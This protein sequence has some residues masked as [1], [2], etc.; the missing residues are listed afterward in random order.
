MK[1]ISFSLYGPD[2]KYTVGAIRNSELAPIVFPGWKMIVY[3]GHDVNRATRATLESKGA[4]V[5]DAIPGIPG[6]LWRFMVNDDPQIERYLIRDTDSRLLPREKRA[7]DAWVASGK[8]FHVI[9]DHPYHRQLIMGGLWGAVHR[10]LPNMGQM[11]ADYHAHT[12]PTM[13]WGHDQ[14]FLA[15]SIWPLVKNECLQHDSCTRAHYPGSVPFPDGLRMGDWRFCGEIF[16]A[17]DE[18]Q[19]N[20]WEQRINF[21]TP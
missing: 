12:A 3:V 17:N 15:N 21:M 10:A 8:K 14:K 5:R 16:D 1:A 19:K 20:Y 4:I 2:P 6:M 18:Q 13:A 11:I 7:V 9:R